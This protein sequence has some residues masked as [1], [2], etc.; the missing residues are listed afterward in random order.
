MKRADITRRMR[1]P[2]KI[3]VPKPTSAP[4]ER[5]WGGAIV[6]VVVVGARKHSQV[7]QSGSSMTSSL[8]QVEA[9]K[10]MQSS[11]SRMR[12]MQSELYCSVKLQIIPFP[13]SII[14]DLRLN[15]R[16]CRLWNWDRRLNETT[17]LLPYM[18]GLVVVNDAFRLLFCPLNPRPFQLPGKKW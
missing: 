6:V 15:M 12:R 9:P 8:S 13:Q 7:G 17:G 3:R 2:T 5:P 10:Q 14:L 1:T 16:C 4:T 11:G 18:L